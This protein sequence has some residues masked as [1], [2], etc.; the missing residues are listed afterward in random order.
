M[1]KEGNQAAQFSDY[2]IPNFQGINRLVFHH[3]LPFGYNLVIYMIPINLFK[4][5]IF[6]TGTFFAN[7]HNGFS[8]LAIYQ[9]YY[10]SMHP[11]LLTTITVSVFL[12]HNQPFS[13]NPLKFTKDGVDTSV[14]PVYNP[15]NSQPFTLENLFNVNAWLSKN[16]I[17]TNQDG[18]TNNITAYFTWVRDTFIK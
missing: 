2:A 17:S 11:V 14:S 8:G 10:Y 15:R 5:L 9:G 18:S 4:G 3:G 1:G 7:F 16:R 6:C 13:K 12:F